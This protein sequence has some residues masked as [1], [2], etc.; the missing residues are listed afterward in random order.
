MLFNERDEIG[1][2][3]ARESRFGEVRIG[4]EE[5]VGRAM[6]VGEIAATSSGDKDFLAEAVGALQDGDAAAALPGFNG[7]EKTSGAGAE[8]DGV[9]FARRYNE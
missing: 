5:I 7:A 9:E 6:N 4:R 8:N 1:R 2:G 3:E